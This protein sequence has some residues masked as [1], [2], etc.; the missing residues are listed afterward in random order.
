[1]LKAI[2]TDNAPQAIG[3][4]SQAVGSN[5]L[6]FVSGQIPLDPTTG[7][8]EQ[9]EIRGQVRQA[10]ENL[11]A[12]I[13]AAGLSLNNVVKATVMIT[14]MNYFPVVNEIYAEYFTG[15]VLPARVVTAVAE[16]PKQSLIEIDAIAAC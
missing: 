7:K 8:I 2:S 13:E 3:P 5:G 1:M 14:D 9:T 10:L 11:K 4:Y 12:I 6:L 15:S 16:L